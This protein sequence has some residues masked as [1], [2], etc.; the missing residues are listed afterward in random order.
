[1]SVWYSFSLLALTS[2]PSSLAPNNYILWTRASRFNGPYIISHPI[3][4]LLRKTSFLFNRNSDERV[5]STATHISFNEDNSLATTVMI[6][7]WSVLQ[8]GSTSQL[9]EC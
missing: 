8:I 6:R 2:F 4:S 9:Q 7:C 5:Q 1:M 3:E